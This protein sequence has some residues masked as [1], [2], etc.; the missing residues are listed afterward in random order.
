MYIGIHSYIHNDND[1]DDGDGAGDGDYID[2]EFQCL[3]CLKKL[4]TY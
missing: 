1:D 3:K 2:F 4:F